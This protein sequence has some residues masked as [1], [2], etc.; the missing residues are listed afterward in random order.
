MMIQVKDDL[1]P[2]Q[3]SF[4]EYRFWQPPD[5]CHYELLRGRLIRMDPPTP[6]HVTISQFLVYQWRQYL[7]SQNLSLVVR[8]ETG[9]R[10]ETSSSRIPDVTICTQALWEKL[11]NRPGGG[12][13]DFAQEEIP[14]L[15]VE[16]VSSNWREDYLR[17]RAEYAIIQVPEYWIVDY[18]RQQVWVL[19][20]P[21]RPEGYEVVKRYPGEVVESLEFSGFS[22]D[23][24]EVL[25]PPFVEDLMRQ[26]QSEQA[27]LRNRADFMAAKLREL[28]VDPDAL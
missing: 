9:V 7:V 15:V 26:A 12:I 25:N 23:V 18:V 8:T 3:L 5:D 20:N 16:V 19:T 22:L 10:T 17:K 28:G 21:D 1:L 11:S 2:E 14:R 27:T 4:E 24:D 6:L 13:L